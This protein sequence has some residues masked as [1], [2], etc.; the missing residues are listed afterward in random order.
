MK[1]AKKKKLRKVQENQFADVPTLTICQSIQLL[2]NELS[3]RGV[4]IKD[5][6]DKDKS[7]K[8]IQ[9]IGGKLYYLSE[10]E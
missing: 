4:Y 2:I 9:Y 1:R 10:R 7:L 5:F 6:D 3:E 8:Q